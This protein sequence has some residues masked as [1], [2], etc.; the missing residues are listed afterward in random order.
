MGQSAP[1]SLHETEVNP[2]RATL[3]IKPPANSFCPIIREANDSTIISQNIVSDESECH[4]CYCEV[5]T[6]DRAVEQTSF[7]SAE[8][9]SSCICT[10][11]SEYECIFTVTSVR[12]GSFVVSVI[13]KER[14]VL[15]DIVNS[16]RDIDASV[17]L[18]RLTRTCTDEESRFEINTSKITDKQREAVDLAVEL[19]YYDCPR[20]ADLEV[21]ADRLDISRSAVSQRL[22]AAEVTLVRSLVSD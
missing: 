19:G 10:A 18:E 2:L 11:A 3:L 20:Q 17:H 22:N 14:E 15:T 13:V 4:T 9:E 16:L 1:G 8:M 6:E 7:I 21:L 5:R 12:N